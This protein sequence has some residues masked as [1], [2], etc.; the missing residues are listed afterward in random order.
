LTIKERKGYDIEDNYNSVKYQTAAKNVLK[1][2]IRRPE[3]NQQTS[4]T[5]AKNVRGN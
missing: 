4:L 2:V 1:G 5:G 3:R